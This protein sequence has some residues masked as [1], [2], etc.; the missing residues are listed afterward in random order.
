MGLDVLY[1]I[2]QKNPLE[3]NRVI[4]VLDGRPITISEA[5]QILQSGG[6]LAQ[7]LSEELARIGMDPPTIPEEWWNIAYYRYLQKPENY[8]VF[9]RGRMWT[10]QEILREIANRT[11]IGADFVRMEMEYMQ[12]LM[13]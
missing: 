9:Y 6:P 13:R 12:Y 3:A 5:I 10:K 1:K 4:V 7:R 11:E 2:I 8:T